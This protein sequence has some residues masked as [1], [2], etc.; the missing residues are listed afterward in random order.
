MFSSQ[1][2]SWKLGSC[3]RSASELHPAL[4]LLFLLRQGLDKSPRLTS[5]WDPSPSPSR[6]AGM[7]GPAASLSEFVP[8][9][10]KQMSHHGSFK[11]GALNWCGDCGH[12]GCQGDGH[13]QRGL[14]V[15]CCPQTLRYLQEGRLKL[16]PLPQPA[17]SSCDS[18]Q[19]G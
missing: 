11:P 16:R 3:T 7:T 18:V 1:C 5:N 6:V 2:W 4:F 17:G 10:E 19:V 13:F 14:H 15:L 8:N 9:T 12:G